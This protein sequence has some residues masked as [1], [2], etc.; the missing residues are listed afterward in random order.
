M[1]RFKP[2]GAFSIII[3]FFNAVRFSDKLCRQ[4]CLSVSTVAVTISD[5]LK[6]LDS[7]MHVTLVNLALEKVSSVR[8]VVSE[9]WKVLLPI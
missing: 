8:V 5:T 9:N 6:E 7:H 3:L 4:H 1:L 2:L